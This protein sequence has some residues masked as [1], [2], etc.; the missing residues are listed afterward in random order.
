M[1]NHVIL[2]ISN[3]VFID[4]LPLLCEHKLSIAEEAV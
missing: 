4:F 2:I 1:P 3:T